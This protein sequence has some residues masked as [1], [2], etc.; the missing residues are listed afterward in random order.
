MR[1]DLALN[2]LVYGSVFPVDLGCDL[3]AV[4]PLLMKLTNFTNLIGGQIW[5]VACLVGIA[6]D[7]PIVDKVLFKRAPFQIFGTVIEL[8]SI[9]VINGVLAIFSR[10]IKSNGDKPMNLLLSPVNLGP[11]IPVASN[12]SRRHATPFAAFDSTKVASKNPFKAGD[13]LPN[14]FHSPFLQKKPAYVKGH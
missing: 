3:G 4:H 9:K 11:A 10:K 8:V 12:I 7:G 14:L 6:Q 13:G 1:P 5:R 2:N